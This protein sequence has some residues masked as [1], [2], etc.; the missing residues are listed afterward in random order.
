MGFNFQY[1]FYEEEI[2]RKKNSRVQEEIP[3]KP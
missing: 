3:L 2:W 1:L